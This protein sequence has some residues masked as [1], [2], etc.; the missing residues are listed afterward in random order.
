MSVFREC[1]ERALDIYDKCYQHYHPSV[2]IALTNLGAVMRSLGD[3]EKS[4][5]KFEKALAMEEHLYEPNHPS[6]SNQTAF[7]MSDSLCNEQSVD[8][9][10]QSLP[11]KPF[12]SMNTI[13]VLPNSAQKQI[14]QV[15]YFLGWATSHA[16]HLL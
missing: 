6:V 2:A 15:N 14:L 8:I 5:E 3:T 13:L 10:Q 11:A 7:F 9:V 1:L 16:L 4:K 12:L